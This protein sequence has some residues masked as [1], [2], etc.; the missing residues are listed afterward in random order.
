MAS[1]RVSDRAVWAC[2]WS[3]WVEVA[4]RESV[5]VSFWDSCS[6]SEEVAVDSVNVDVAVVDVDSIID[7]DDSVGFVGGGD[8]VDLVVGDE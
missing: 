8:T 6:F 3:C 1:A 4:A 5:C 7:D 2:W